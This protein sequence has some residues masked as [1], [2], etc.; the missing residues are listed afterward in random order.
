MVSFTP[1]MQKAFRIGIDIPASLTY[2]VKPQASVAACDTAPKG[3]ATACFEVYTQPKGSIGIVAYWQRRGV[4]CKWHWA[5]PTCK[6]LY[7]LSLL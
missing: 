3:D 2:Y 7:H 4:S 5:I 6:V 1:Y